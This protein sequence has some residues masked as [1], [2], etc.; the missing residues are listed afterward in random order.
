MGAKG[1]RHSK[2]PRRLSR[3]GQLSGRDLPSRSSPHDGPVRGTGVSRV[4]IGILVLGGIVGAFIWSYQPTVDRLVR[5][6]STEPDYSHGFL[7]VPLALGFLWYRRESFPGFAGPS[8]GGL[9]LVAFSVVIRCLGSAYYLDAVE[10]WSLIVWCAGAIWL[11][12]GTQVVIWAWPAVVFL[13]FMIPL[14][15]RAERL[16]SLP[17]QDVA[18][19]MSVW[20]LQLL[21]QPALPEGHVIRIGNQALEV[22]EAC[23]GLRVFLGI[24]SLAFAYVILARRSWWENCILLAAVLPVALL[25]NSLRIVVTALLYSF[26]TSEIAQK[27]SHDFSGW[28]MIPTAVALFGLVALYLKTI[29]PESQVM[30]VREIV[31]HQSV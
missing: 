25:A 14:P 10:D 12:A 2:D 8:W 7:V 15:F 24:I 6:W 22:A 13:F 30:E 3:N 21:G 23:S 18:T 5:T 29:F 31:R 26:S 28:A 11:L 27:F 4:A 16:L 1:Q 19:K 17:L 9:A 20:I